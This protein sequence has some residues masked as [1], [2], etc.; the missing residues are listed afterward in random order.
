MIGGTGNDR[1]EGVAFDVAG[2]IHLTG[3]TFSTDFPTTAGASQRALRGVRSAFY[4]V[5]PP[6]L[7][8]MLVST[9]TAAAAPTSDERSRRNPE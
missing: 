9:L 1:A 3:T 5:M 6:D 7:K 2:N 8:T 4:V